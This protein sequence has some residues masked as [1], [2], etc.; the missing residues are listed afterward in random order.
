MG[1]ATTAAS[2][3]QLPRVV[4]RSRRWWPSPRFRTCRH[5]DR[6]RRPNRFPPRR[7]VPGRGCGPSSRC[8][9]GRNANSSS[10]VP[11]FAVAFTAS[12]TRS[13][14]CWLRL[15]CTGSERH[16]H[17]GLLSLG[18]STCDWNGR[19]PGGSGSGRTLPVPMFY[20]SRQRRCHAVAI[21]RN[22]DRVLVVNVHGTL[23]RR[24]A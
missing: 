3:P 22:A 21:F 4:P 17:S 20:S 16:S 23:V 2:M 5:P 13:R 19:E 7:A 12:T 8:R 9:Q 18:S 15:G 6:P 11:A 1:V 24:L 14:S 10:Q